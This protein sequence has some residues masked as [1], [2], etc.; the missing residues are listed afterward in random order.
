MLGKHFS[1]N[2]DVLGFAYNTDRQMNSIGYGDKGLD[3]FDP[4]GPC[5][6]GVIDLRGQDNLNDGM[7]IE[8]GVIPVA[9]SVT[10]PAAFAVQAKMVGKDTAKGWADD[11]RQFAR[12]VESLIRGAYDGAMKHTQIYLVMTH[13]DANGEMYLQD[14]RL[15]IKWPGVGQPGNFR[16]GQRKTSPRPPKRT[17]AYLSRILSGPSFFGHDLITVHPLGG[18]VMGKDT[19]CGGREPQRAGVCQPR[20]YP[21]LRGALCYR[22]VCYPQS[23]RGE[24][25]SD[26]LGHFG[27]VLRAD[28]QGQGLEVQRRAALCTRPACNS[29]QDRHPFHRDDERL[30]FYQ[31]QRR[32]S[33][34]L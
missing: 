6:T 22:W 8:E 28:R 13:D 23:G 18:C 15:R 30:L 25:P 20:W 2:A 34:G 32:F 4:V 31:S 1:G 26:H 19:R 7:I 5:I 17:T 24:S 27:T 21:G 33:E 14:D 12:E 11:A 10:L 3:R 29:G 9:L 16:K